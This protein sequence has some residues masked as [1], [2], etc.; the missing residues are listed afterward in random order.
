MSSEEHVHNEPESSAVSM[1]F[2]GWSALGAVLLLALAIGVLATIYN[3]VVPT[4]TMP[5]PETFS[6][7]RVDTHDAEELQKIQSAQAKKLE[8]WGWADDQHTL[9]QVPVARAMQMLTA[10]GGDAYAPLLPPEPALS[11]PTSAAQRA[12][13]SG[14]MS[15]DPHRTAG[16]GTPPEA[17]P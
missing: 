12:V 14:E 9:V 7:P 16:Q 17:K 8:S 4:K 15:Q 10:K 5:A 13:M 3:A 6:Q 11:S 1:T 2:V